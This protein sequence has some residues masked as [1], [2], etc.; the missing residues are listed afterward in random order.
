MTYY[1]RLGPCES[2]APQLLAPP[3]RVI[4]HVPGVDAFVEFD[5]AA[6]PLM[7]ES[8]AAL[9]LPYAFAWDET[10]QSYKI[11]AT[12]IEPW[13]KLKP[14]RNREVLRRLRRCAQWAAADKRLCEGVT[15][16]SA[17]HQGCVPFFPRYKR[18]AIVRPGEAHPFRYS[19]REARGKAP[20]LVYLHSAA[21]FGQNGVGSVREAALL[22]LLVPRKCHI[23]VPQDGLGRTF[24]TD[25]FTRNLWEAIDRTPH[26]DRTRI[27]IAGISYG[28]YGAVMACRRSPG[29]FAACVPAVAALANLNEPLGEAD[30]DAL[31]QTPMWLGYSGAEQR[32]NEALYEAL[33]A[34]GADVKRTFI[35]HLGHNPAGPVFLLTRPW[36]KW[37][38]NH[39]TGEKS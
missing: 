6:L 9:G 15:E 23:L 8:V 31:A 13:N 22:P 24:N 30:F 14:G 20:L 35:R 19:L 37:L 21:G 32:L 5:E 36:G 16:T 1:A 3:F 28:G 25:G 34:R 12:A 26:V 29:D 2:Q 33:Q 27:Y 7:Q 17:V 39:T 10:R 4:A 11:M 18:F 38:F